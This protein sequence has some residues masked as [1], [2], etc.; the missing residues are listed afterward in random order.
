[1]FSYFELFIA[2]IYHTNTTNLN[3]LS[4]SVITSVSY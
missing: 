3:T 1:M 2:V 4:C